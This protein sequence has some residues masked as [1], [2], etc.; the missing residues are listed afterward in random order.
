MW[1]LLASP[2]NDVG[3][4]GEGKPANPDRGDDVKECTS[5]T[6][7]RLAPGA[8][9]AEFR[10]DSVSTCFCPVYSDDGVWYWVFNPNISV[11]SA[12]S[13]KFAVDGEGGEAPKRIPIP[14]SALP[15]PTK[16]API[17]SS[18]RILPRS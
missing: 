14:M 10:G 1:R 5:S 3:D 17:P 16:A 7:T 6:K 2:L 13:C 15:P 11:F 9:S 18:A 4:V 8:S 12:P